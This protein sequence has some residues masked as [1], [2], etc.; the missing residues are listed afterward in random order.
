MK[1][2]LALKCCL[3]LGAVAVLLDLS[4]V[5]AHPRRPKAR[6]QRIQTVNNLWS[7][8]FTLLSTNAHPATRLH[9]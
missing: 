4:Y 7:V 8:T 2:K 1:P 5:S 9:E 6:I 3:I